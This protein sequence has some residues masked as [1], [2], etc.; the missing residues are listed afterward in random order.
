MKMSTELANTVNAFQQECVTFTGPYNDAHDR[1]VKLAES[2]GKEITQEDIDFLRQITEEL[3]E[4]ATYLA[5][6]LDNA[7]M[8]LDE[9]IDEIEN[10]DD[11]EEA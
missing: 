11:E 7:L 1:I 6:N 5:S 2:E 4:Y 8:D 9:E 10:P 3:S